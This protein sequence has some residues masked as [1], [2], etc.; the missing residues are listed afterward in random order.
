MKPAI[1]L[2][3]LT[4]FSQQLLAQFDTSK[5][6]FFNRAYQVE[7][8]VEYASF[9]GVP[10]KITEKIHQVTF[11]TLDGDKVAMGEYRNKKFK[12]RHGVFV[13]Y[14][15]NG[16]I[17]VSSTYRNGILNGPYLRFFDNGQLSDSGFVRRGNFSGYWKSWYDNGQPRVF[18]KYSRITVRYG[19]EVSFLD[20]EYKSWFR[21]GKLDDSGL[22]K[23]NQRI[24]IWVDWLEEGKV[25]SIGLY[26]KNWKKGLWRYYDASGKLLYMRRFSA[27]KYD[28]EGEFIPVSR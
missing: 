25:R 17:I 7:K 28:D 20:D 6:V 4:L 22:Y 23:N 21:N 27:F 9:F 26:R 16:R 14:N 19:R 1:F 5:I 10:E 18:C 12:N 24:G 8:N 2:S 15:K 13:L 3:L 11:Y